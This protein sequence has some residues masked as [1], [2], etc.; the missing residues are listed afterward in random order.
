MQEIVIAISASP[1]A[2]LLQAH[3]ARVSHPC[4]YGAHDLL[5]AYWAVF[6]NLS[7][8]FTCDQVATGQEQ[9]VRQAVKAHFTGC[10][11][12]ELFVFLLQFCKCVQ[13]KCYSTVISVMVNLQFFAIHNIFIGLQINSFL[14]VL[15]SFVQKRQYTSL[16]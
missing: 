10:H 3:V 7:T 9:G 1:P 16:G 4:F 5:P 2:N 15:V 13:R 14:N 8:I 6:Q 11:S 12:S